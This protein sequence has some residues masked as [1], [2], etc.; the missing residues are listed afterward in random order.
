MQ[1]QITN[2]IFEY[3]GYECEIKESP[4]GLFGCGYVKLPKGHKYY[5]EDDA[6]LLIKC[7]GGLNFSEQI[8]DKWVIGFD[9]GHWDDMVP[10][11]RIREE[12]AD[13]SKVPESEIMKIGDNIYLKSHV[14]L[15]NNDII[16]STFKDNEFI[17]NE[18]KRIVDQLCNIK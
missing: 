6:S 4:A 2:K 13:L 3:K 17:E 12:N 7:H 5:G 16:K 10:A 11:Y 15:N 9:C 1:Y 18:I 14:H 8:D